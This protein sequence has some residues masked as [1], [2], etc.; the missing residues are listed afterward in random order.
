MIRTLKFAS[1][2][3]A[4]VLLTGC[5]TPF[6]VTADSLCKDWR[7]QTVSKHDSLTQ[8]TASNMEASNASRVTYGCHPTKNEAKS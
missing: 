7:V 8:D 5:A 2:L 3:S 6:V 4:L 1:A